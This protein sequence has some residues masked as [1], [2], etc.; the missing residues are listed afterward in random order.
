[1]R[2]FTTGLAAVALLAIVIFS[3]QNLEAIEVS[4]LF[5]SAKISKCV[6]MI[7]TYVLGMVSGWGLVELFKKFMQK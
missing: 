5:W 4:F 6:V 7:G 3:I 2:Y 1:M